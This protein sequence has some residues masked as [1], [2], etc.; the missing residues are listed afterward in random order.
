[1]LRRRWDVQRL[2]RLRNSGQHDFGRRQLAGAAT[3]SK[4]CRWV[5]TLAIVFAASAARA[6]IK[7]CNEFPYKVYIAIA[8]PQTADSWLS[9]GWMSLEK[10]DCS[11]FDYAL[12][13]S[14]F[15]YRAESVDYRDA[16]KKVKMVWGTGRKFA[17]WENDN[18]N[19]WGAQ[20][21]VLKSTLEE[22]TQ[23][24]ESMGDDSSITVTFQPEGKVTKTISTNSK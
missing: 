1:M 18:F 23:G 10:G 2:V 22:F 11:V 12:K 13:P 20:E 17:I 24:V 5:I 8:Y 19:Y 4:S 3:M 9:R 21:R 14:A 7:F 6:E 15:Y 16:G